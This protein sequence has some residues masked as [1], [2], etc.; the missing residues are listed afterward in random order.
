MANGIES[1]H[2]AVRSAQGEDRPAYQPAAP[3]TGNEFGFAKATEAT[4]WADPTSAW[5]RC[6][7][8]RRFR[9][10]DRD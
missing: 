5:G 1:S 9:A 2:G 10:V 6:W 8:L 7:K 3:W 4:G